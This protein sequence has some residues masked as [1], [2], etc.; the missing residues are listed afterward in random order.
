MEVVGFRS[1]RYLLYDSELDMTQ[2]TRRG[3]ITGL[4]GKSIYDVIKQSVCS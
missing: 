3:T 4:D 1:G 2:N